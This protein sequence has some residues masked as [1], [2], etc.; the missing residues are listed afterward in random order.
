MGSYV[1]GVD[2]G[3]ESGRAAVVDL[4]DGRVLGEASME[5]P[6]AVMD[7]TFLDGTRLP[8]EFALHHPQDYLD[9]LAH[10]V[11]AAMSEA[12]VEAA[13]VIGL[14]LD[15]TSCSILPTDAAGA[16]L[17]FEARFANRPHAFVKVWKHHA[18]Q[19]QARHFSAVCEERDPEL[20]AEY[21]GTISSEWLI[22][23]S[24]EIFEADREVFDAAARIIEVE[25]WLVWQLT[26]NEL[27]NSG[28]AGY[29]ACYRWERGSYP[30]AELLEATAEGFSGLLPKLD[31]ELANPGTRAGFLTD[32]WA[33]RLG[34]PS[35]V[36]VPV[37]N[38][39][40]HGAVVAAG[41]SGPG[42]MLL[43]MGTSVCN[44]LVGEDK[45]PVPGISGAVHSGML[46]DVWGYE[47]G[48]S[49]VGD[50][51]NW[52]VRNMAPHDIHVEAQERGISPHQVL[53]EQILADGEDADRPDLLA[54]EWINGNRSVLVDADLSGLLLG[55]T[56]GTRAR[57]IY[58]TF[59]EA[60]C[61]GQ[62]IIIE[63]FERHGIQIT[64]IIACGGLASKNPV[65]MQTLAD[66]TGREV[67]VTK[68]ENLSALGAALHAAVAAGAEAGGFETLTEAA[69]L[70][71]GIATTYQPR[72]EAQPRMEALMAT[73]RELHQHYGVDRKSVM[74]GL[75]AKHY[76]L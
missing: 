73:Y 12:G 14:G 72:P 29:K 23:K 33:N 50:V 30:S 24:L 35:K 54:L 45:A 64:E 10:V 55:L 74:H 21:G 36:A 61:F 32:E 15:T 27:R 34:L 8:A 16:P 52:Y 48:Q 6:H 75:K 70:G 9:V 56:M 71:G 58:R 37:G 13:Q 60:A 26:G 4:G 76:Q 63:N 69:A 43:V 17:A 2:F 62:E 20:I 31:A 7:E 38:M 3:T 22:P 65:L 25:D 39:D 18:A 46:P 57:D 41:L 67:K 40:A 19:P 68:I 47:A 53:I 66:V 11:P 5:Y 59:I 28:A 1:I 49:G 44:M 42:P 51:L